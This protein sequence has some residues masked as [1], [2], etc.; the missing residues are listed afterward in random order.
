[1]V[2]GLNELIEQR[3]LNF[4]NIFVMVD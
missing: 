4:I 1:M 3:V 2:H